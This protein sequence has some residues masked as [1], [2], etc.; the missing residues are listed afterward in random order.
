M[1]IRA[2]IMSGFLILAAMLL[3]A[4]AWSIYE[5][6]NIG[7]SAQAILDENYKS[8]DAAKVMIE[9]LER[10]DS[11][12]LLLLLG[13]REEGLAIMKSADESFQKA[14]ETARTNVTI[15]GEQEYIDAVTRAYGTYKN[16][17]MQF[18]IKPQYRGDLNW[19]FR[20]VNP[21]FLKAKMA[22]S[23]LMNLNHQI[24]YKTASH[25][26]SRAHRAT[27]PGIIAIVSA[28]IFAVIFI[29]LIDHYIINPIVQLT[30]GIQDYLERGKPLNVRVETEDEISRMVSSVEQLIK[31][32]VK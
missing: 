22:V 28:F 25:L 23:D 14:Y 6:K 11:A 19:Y 1:G 10:E 15:P 29:F 24:M 18:I 13:R 2:K 7:V 16:L 12:T 17:W 31:K 21:N 9:S 27:M 3:V 32:S 8:I 30:S 5:L 26:E 4:G 20:E